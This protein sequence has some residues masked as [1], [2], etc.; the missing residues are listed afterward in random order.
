MSK[1][2]QNYI[3]YLITQLSQVSTPIPLIYFPNDR[4]KREGIKTQ[5]SW[6]AVLTTLALT[7]ASVVLGRGADSVEHLLSPEGNNYGVCRG[8]RSCGFLSLPLPGKQG[9]QAY[10]QISP[11]GPPQLAD[12]DGALQTEDLRGP[13]L[14]DWGRHL[15]LP[16]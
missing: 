8:R 14:P 10:K 1:V 15:Q 7:I 3:V 13:T 5:V 9:K 2:T 12:S 6:E 11:S 4:N 16:E